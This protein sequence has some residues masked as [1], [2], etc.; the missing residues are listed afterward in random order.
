[1]VLAFYTISYVLRCLQVGAVYLDLRVNSKI[2]NTWLAFSTL[3]T[4]DTGRFSENG[5]V[6]Q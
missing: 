4:V 2:Q 3:D 1:M 5:H 6:S